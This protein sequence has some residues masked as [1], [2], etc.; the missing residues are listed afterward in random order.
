M[1]FI[2]DC[3][4]LLYEEVTRKSTLVVVNS[5]NSTTSTSVHGGVGCIDCSKNTRACSCS[6]RAGR[7]QSRV[8]RQQTWSKKGTDSSTDPMMAEKL[9]INEVQRV[10]YSIAWACKTS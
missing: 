7:S 8:E 9:Q 5:S 4:S 1:V 3:Y 10:E 2:L 6:A